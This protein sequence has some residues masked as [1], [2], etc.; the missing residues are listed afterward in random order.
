METARQGN[1]REESN[2]TIRCSPAVVDCRYEG[3]R[4]SHDY[5]QKIEYLDY[6][7]GKNA[8]QQGLGISRSCNLFKWVALVAIRTCTLCNYLHIVQE[9]RC[10]R[11]LAALAATL[12]APVTLSMC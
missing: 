9:R 4:I 12:A 8:G 11:P 1:L 3:E 2:S 10:N 7:R 6:G 5:M